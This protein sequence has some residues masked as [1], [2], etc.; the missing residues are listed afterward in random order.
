MDIY[1]EDF[2]LSNL[3][4]NFSLL[5]LV[6]ITTKSQT[7]KF[8]MLVSSLIGSICGI[9]CLGFLK[10]MLL[11]N[12]LK[13]ICATAMIKLAFNSKKKQFV[14]NFLLLFVYTFAMGGIVNYFTSNQ[15]F[16]SFGIIAVNKISLLKIS[17][18]VAVV[19]L[20]F[21]KITTNL[22]LKITQSN[23]VYQTTLC[24]KRKKI[25]INAFLDTGNLLSVDG[26]PVVV[27]SYLSFLELTN[28]SPNSFKSAEIKSNTVSGQSKMKVYQLDYIEIK[29]KHKIHRFKNQYISVNTNTT[30]TNTN[31]QALLSPMLL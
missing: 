19:S 13:L 26:K 7:T 21:K 15:L 31:Y 18:I 11:T 2:V 4:I 23:L 14:F 16:F 27:V 24:L 12:L 5:Q 30:F 1:I 29:I 25:K 9:V 22:K 3:I 10:N 17:A 8:K 6:K 20:V 28:F